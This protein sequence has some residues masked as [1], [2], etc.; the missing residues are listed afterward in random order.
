MLGADAA[1]LSHS[2][3]HRIELWILDGSRTGQPAGIRRLIVLAGAGL[4]LDGAGAGVEPGLPWL[5]R[6]WRPPWPS[7]VSRTTT[8][9][10]GRS[11]HRYD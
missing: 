11:P 1:R 6:R 4:D 7:G 9:P 3:T 10:S 5:L 8:N 2:H